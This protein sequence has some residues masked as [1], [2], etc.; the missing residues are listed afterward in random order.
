MNLTLGL[1]SIVLYILAALA[2]GRRLRAAPAGL[3]G[4]AFDRFTIATALAISVHGTMLYFAVLRN[5]GL[6]LGLFDAASMISWAIVMVFAIG[7][8]F[9][10][11]ANLGF[12]VLPLAAITVGC[13]VVWPSTP[14][15]A[16]SGG[17]GLQ[18]HV[19]ISV[20]AYGVLT[21]AAF[22]ALLLA[23]QNNRLKQKRPLGLA[24]ILP[25]L[26]TQEALLFQFV[27]LGFFLLSLSLLSGF[28]FI[29]NLFAQH[30]AHKTILSVSAWLVFGLLLWGRAVH[31]WRGRTAIRL[32]LTGFGVLLLAYFG[33]K[34]V[35][36]VVLQRYWFAT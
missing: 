16:E 32:S 10:A 8:I 30:L 4:L 23:Y 9:K 11:M 5:Q 29:E 15:P 1:F 21:I 34:L 14:A 6:N 28:T 19:V 26:Q 12:F 22:Q 2:L 3:P 27:G 17:L 13:A 18:M 25:A 20:F 35:L 36:E 33:S 24:R 7:S 31:G